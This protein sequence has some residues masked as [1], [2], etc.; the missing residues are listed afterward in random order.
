M[1]NRFIL[2]GAALVLTSSMAIASPAPYVG[3]GLGITTNTSSFGSYRGVPFNVFAGYG[4]VVNQNFYLAG[5]LDANVGTAEISNKSSGLKTTYSYG[6]SVLPGVMLS[7][8]TLA[9]ARVGVVRAHFTS[10]SNNSTGGEVGLGMQTN[11]TQNLDLRGEYNYISYRSINVAGLSTSPRSD[12]AKIA[13][14]YKF[15]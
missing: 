14:V 11:L 12:V 1:L 4:G 10:P 5:E 13:L 9:F 3:A 6:A 8:R 15:D 7:D 2:T